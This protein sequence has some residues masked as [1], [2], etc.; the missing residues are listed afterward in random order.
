MKRYII[1]LI[2]IFLISLVSAQINIFG[3]KHPPDAPGI[4]CVSAG[5]KVI[6]DVDFQWNTIYNVYM[7]NATLTGV[8]L[9]NVT[10]SEVQQINATEVLGE[11]WVD[12]TGD[13]MSG[14]LDM[15][16]NN[17]INIAFITADDWSNITILQSQISDLTVYSAGTGII[18]TGDVF[19]FDTIYG[20]SLYIELT[21]NFGGDVSGTYDNLQ[22]N[23]NIVESIACDPNS[24]V[25]CVNKTNVFIAD[26]QINNSFKLNFYNSSNYFFYNNT[27]QTLQLWVNGELQQDWGA[28]TTIYQEATFL[29]NAIFQNLSGEEILLEGNLRATG[30]LKTDYIFIGNG[31]N[32]TD[33]CHPDGTGCP[34][35][36]G[37]AIIN[38][39]WVEIT[40]D[41]MTG[42]LY[43]NGTISSLYLEGILQWSNL[44]NVPQ[45]K[46]DTSNSQYLNNDTEYIYFNE[47]LM[48]ETV[49]DRFALREENVSITV[50]SGDGNNITIDCCYPSAE[51]LQVAVFPTTITNNYR[52]EAYGTSSL[53]VV[54]TDRTPHTGDWIIGHRGVVLYGETI[55]MNITNAN[56]DEQFI[57]RIRWRP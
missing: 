38:P 54:D 52:F 29:A 48:N 49:E 31:S 39:I 33:V 19:S 28:S 46:W 32:I 40:G 16:G 13:T 4:L 50:S 25:A 36:N 24:N 26:Q 9:E 2:F 34:V 17:I 18:L 23:P 11:F 3:P 51:I 35:I 6:G 1:P 5:C 53:D 20:N 27:N 41:N 7:F 47:L 42:D 55:T 56:I 21:D 43:V 10:Y 22:I 57:I 14:E 12:E 44:T 15:D 30:Y 8:T 37:T 45:I